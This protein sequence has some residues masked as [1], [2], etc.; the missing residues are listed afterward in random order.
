LKVEVVRF[1]WVRRLA[2]P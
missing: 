2:T 1:P